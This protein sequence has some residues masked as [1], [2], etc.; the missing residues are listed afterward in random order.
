MQTL[1]LSALRIC[2]VELE[3]G[4]SYSQWLKQVDILSNFLILKLRLFQRLRVIF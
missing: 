4:F 1:T 3:G 2:N